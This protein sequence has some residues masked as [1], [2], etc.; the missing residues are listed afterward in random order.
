MP[1]QIIPP[2]N[3]K[4]RKATFYVKVVTLNGK[5]QRIFRARN[6]RAAIV[7]R[8]V[9]HTARKTLTLAEMRSTAN[10]GSY[11]LYEHRSDGTL[12]KI[13]L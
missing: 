8:N 5:K 13:A 11:S 1:K 7:C 10:K 9:T 3:F 2:V 4:G 12:R 6:R